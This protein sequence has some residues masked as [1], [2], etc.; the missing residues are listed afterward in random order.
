MD[1]T[2]M[3]D[4]LGTD[5][6]FIRFEL[7]AHAAMTCV[8]CRSLPGMKRETRRRGRPVL[9]SRSVSAEWAPARRL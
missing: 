3:D 2:C 6:C 4:A 7:T 1:D 5:D 9:I 8:C